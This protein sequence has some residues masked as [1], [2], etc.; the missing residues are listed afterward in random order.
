VHALRHLTI[1]RAASTLGLAMI[2]A[3]PRPASAQV[4][5]VVGT[6]T[7]IAALTL[8]DV[9]RIFAAKVTAFEDGTIIT[10]AFDARVENAAFKSLY[11]MSADAMKKRWAT[12]IFQ[13]FGMSM[14][15]S[16][17]TAEEIVK[18]VG[19][20]RGAIAFIAAKDVTGG[21]KVIKVDGLL[22]SDANYPIK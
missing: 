8:D 1:R 18:F 13:G 7:P 12:T 14:P 22:P 10:V 4:A 11:A 9:K 20:R 6:N 15:H 5:I 3:L 2:V 16:L 21:T 17:E 19:S